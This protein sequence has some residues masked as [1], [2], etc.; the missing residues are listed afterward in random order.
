MATAEGTT[1]AVFPEGGLS[2]TGQVGAAKMGLLSYIV[3]GFDPA[4]RDVVFVPVGLAY[5]RV[6]EDRVLTEAAAEGTRRFRAKVF[7]MLRFG[8]KLVWQKLRGQF[9]GFG[10][11][12]AGF[13]APLSLRDWA[14]PGQ[15]PQTEALGAELMARI[16]VSVPILSVPL[17][18]AALAEG[19]I[20]QVDLEARVARLMQDLRAKGAALRL[21]NEAELLTEGLA[22][23]VARG[24]VSNEAGQLRVN[25]W[26]E[27]IVAFYAAPVFQALGQGLPNAATQRT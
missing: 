20:A 21:G 18:A 5:D 23:L 27:G 3:A 16:V 9:N 15:V 13:G 12:S 1:Q 19:P 17:I 2:L 7:V 26:G 4:G 8:I 6:L 22:P 10:I 24:F 25:A 14:V 11:A